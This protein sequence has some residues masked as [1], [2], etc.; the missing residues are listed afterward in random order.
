MT[1]PMPLRLF[2]RLLDTHGPRP[3]GWPARERAG[4]EALLAASAAARA[5]LDQARRLD[6]A[7]GA[8]LPAPSSDSVARLRAAVAREIAR[9]PLPA[10]PGPWDRLLASLRPAAPAGWGALA[11]MASCALWLSLSSAP[12]PAQVG[13]PLAPLQILPIAEDPL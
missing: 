10:R 6:A 5:T 2:A 7:L 11:A 9:T 12:A 8:A 4:A 1:H 3:A 13:D